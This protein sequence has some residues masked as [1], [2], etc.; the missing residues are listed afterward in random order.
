MTLLTLRSMVNITG[1]CVDLHC[2]VFTG[3]E[4]PWSPSEKQ[5]LLSG[6]LDTL[7]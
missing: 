4:D 5:F 3:S 7:V 2:F 1:Y 6:A